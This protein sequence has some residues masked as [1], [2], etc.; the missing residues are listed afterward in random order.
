MD[1]LSYS[2]NSKC[3]NAAS[4]QYW[5]QLAQLCQ[6]QISN[7]NKVKNPVTD[8]I[9]KSLMNFKRDSNLQENLVNS[10]KFLLDLIFTKLNLVGITC[11]QEFE[12]QYK[13]QTA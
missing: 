12:L 6:L 5:E 10:P 8:S 11:M 7:R 3:L 4:R 9:F 13:C 2:K 1:V